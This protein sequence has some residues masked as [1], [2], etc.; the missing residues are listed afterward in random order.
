MKFIAPYEEERIMHEDGHSFFDD[1]Q[2]EAVRHVFS[3]PAGADDQPVL[4]LMPDFANDFTPDLIW[5]EVGRLLFIKRE[6]QSANPL[7]LPEDCLTGL[8]K[9][10]GR[11]D[12]VVFSL[13]GL[14][15]IFRAKL[16]YDRSTFAAIK[17]VSLSRQAGP[18]E[19]LVCSDVKGFEDLER[20]RPG[21]RALR[22]WVPKVA[23]LRGHW[24]FDAI[25]FDNILYFSESTPLEDSGLEKTS[26][27]INLVT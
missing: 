1:Q 6:R 21:Y 3:R 24:P 2:L 26:C 15:D 13:A 4:E 19:V 20:L 17:T 18:R 12:F 14:E 22:S 25:V 9:T 7:K 10:G 8:L 27:E 23:C 16:I 11:G 5:S